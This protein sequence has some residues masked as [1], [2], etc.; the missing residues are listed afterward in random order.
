MSSRMR[1]TSTST[2]RRS[3][4]K[5]PRRGES[6]P[7]QPAPEKM[8]RVGLHATSQVLTADG[9]A[10]ISSLAGKTGVR[11]WTGCVWA[12]ASVTAGVSNHTKYLVSLTNGLTLCCDKNQTWPVAQSSGP[13]EPPQISL[14]GVSTLDL[15]SGD[16]MFPFNTPPMRTDFGEGAGARDLQKARELARDTVES[17][18]SNRSPD[19]LPEATASYGDK[20]GF[21]FLGAWIEAQ[22]GHIVAP[23]GILQ[24]LQLM[25]LR[26]G[27]GVGH[28]VARGETGEELLLPRSAEPR[29]G[30][31]ADARCFIDHAPPPRIK[32]V[33]KTS[34][35]RAISYHLCI[36][37]AGTPEKPR[38]YSVV[39]DG[40]LLLAPALASQIDG[41]DTST[42]SLATLLDDGSPR[43]L[44][45]S[46]NASRAVWASANDGGDD[47]VGGSPFKTTT[48]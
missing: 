38:A 17:I 45:R 24:Q 29:T 2:R 36:N 47:G 20:L 3:Q 30:C 46:P 32:S 6:P 19:T 34:R 11:V 9:F 12:E 41:S 4:R 28:R 35:R 43:S 8:F 48:V 26:L 18:R 27:V 31:L 15:K 14:K 1:G 10:A 39:A 7:A 5:A 22:N 16:T 21:A 37:A 42:D 33:V 44:P 13:M 40:M 23:G 25:M